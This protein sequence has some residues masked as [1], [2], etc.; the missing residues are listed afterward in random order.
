MALFTDSDVVTL[1]DLLQF[2]STLGQVSSTHGID[3][4]T[5]IK[6][7]VDAIG[8]KILLFLLRAGHSDPQW[9]NR[10]LIGLSTV[11]VTPAVFKWVCLE[12]LSRTFAEAYNLQL[13]TRF[14]GKWDEYQKQAETASEI[15]FA[16]GIGIVSNPLP[17]P[18][19]P[20][21][22]TGVGTFSAPAL[23]VR[24]AWTDAQGFEGAPSPISGVVLSG[25]SA[26]S[27]AM[28][29]QETSVPGP[30]VGWNLYASQ[31]QNSFARQ[32]M[33][34][35]PVEEPWA[36]PASGLVTGPL[37]GTGQMP[38]RFVSSSRRWSRG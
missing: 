3:V 20:I 6:L 37:S 22:T 15:V 16:S 9:L 17:K 13:N 7:A 31:T 11:V 28:A 12:S 1:D 35:I 18:A 19:L 10:A 14:Q 38:N 27:I 26:V 21:C 29:E 36:M 23:F 24:V 30:A 34:P 8:D 2:E 4:T 33:V 32:N 25:S 5:K